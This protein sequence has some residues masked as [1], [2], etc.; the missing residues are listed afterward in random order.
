MR[1][2]PSP[3]HGTSANT[4][5]NRIGLLSSPPFPASIRNGNFCAWWFVTINAGELLRFVW[6]VKRFARC[7]DASFA[8]TTP[9]GA[10]APVSPLAL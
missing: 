6:C 7:S 3:E 9:A 10:S 1:K 2:V 8:T 4:R 5:S